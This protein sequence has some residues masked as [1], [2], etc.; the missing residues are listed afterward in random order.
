[1][2]GIVCVGIFFYSLPSFQVQSTHKRKNNTNFAYLLSD[3]MISEIVIV[4]NFI[5]F[6]LSISDVRHANV[7]PISVCLVS[8]VCQRQVFLAVFLLDFGQWEYLPSQLIIS[9]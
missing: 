8:L 2:N 9:E 5:Y 1:M 4:V 6:V 3:E 7:N